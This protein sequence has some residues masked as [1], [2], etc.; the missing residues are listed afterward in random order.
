MLFL[1]NWVIRGPSCP[2]CMVELKELNATKCLKF[3][4]HFLEIARFI[5]GNFFDYLNNACCQEIHII[6]TNH[7]IQI[8][9]THCQTHNTLDPTRILQPCQVLHMFSML[10]M[11]NGLMFAPFLRNS[12]IYFKQF[13]YSPTMQ[14]KILQPVF[15]YRHK[16]F[17]PTKMLQPHQVLHMFSMLQKA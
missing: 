9:L 14:Y 6:L 1:E 15:K 16:T 13:C 12:P 17:D 8:P 4:S 11:Q 5:L 7:A 2:D 10:Y 3:W